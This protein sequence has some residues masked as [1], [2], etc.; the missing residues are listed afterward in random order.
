MVGPFRRPEGVG[1]PSRIAGRGMEALPKGWERSGGPLGGLV[2]VDSPPWMVGR[3]QNGRE[4]LGVPPE[5]AGG[6][7]GSPRRPRGFG[8]LFLRDGNCQ[9]GQEWSVVLPGM[10][11][12]I[13]NSVPEDL[14]G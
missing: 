2:R 5:W 7:G 4:R 13:G 14:R 8:S 1:M 10:M 12:E 11:G 9:E 3:G 6:L